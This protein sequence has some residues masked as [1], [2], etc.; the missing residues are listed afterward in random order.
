MP[1][2]TPITVK[3]KKTAKTHKVAAAGMSGHLPPVAIAAI[4]NHGRKIEAMLRTLLLQFS[5]ASWEI[6]GSFIQYP[7][8]F[9]NR[10]LLPIFP[11]RNKFCYANLI[12]MITLSESAGKRRQ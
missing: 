10:M 12:S 7:S 4:N 1:I 2:A 9:S 8:K 3:P 6:K 5:F 11:S